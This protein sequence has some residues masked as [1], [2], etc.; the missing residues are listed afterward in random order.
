MRWLVQAEIDEGRRAGVV[1]EF[2]RLRFPESQR[3][4][5]TSYHVSILSIE[6]HRSPPPSSQPI[7]DRALSDVEIEQMRLALSTFRD[8][9][10]QFLKS[11]REHMPSF[12]D[13]E[14]VTALVCGGET[15]ENKGIFDVIVPSPGS[16]P[17]AISCKMSIT[18]PDTHKASFMELSNSQKKFQDEFDRLGIDWRSEPEYAG[19]AVV[20]LVTKWHHD[21]ANRADLDS[22]R[23]LILSH[24]KR[25]QQFRL[26]C[27]SLNLTIADPYARVEWCNEGGSAT[28][29]PSTV[30]GYI[31]H[32]G[33]WHRLWQLFQRSG[34]QLKYYPPFAWADWIS[35]AFSLELPPVTSIRDKVDEYFPGKWPSSPLNP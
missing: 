23:Y 19:P 22:S 14:R 21:E 9:S 24:D 20:E 1:L 15:M 26:L 5:I 29:G 17:F 28:D 35:D 11:I 6:I 3:K 31:D 27:Y 12:L 13:F 2:P 25:W 34:G 4:F 7:K 32:E 18:Q 30:A 33:R 8:G 16:L 10:G